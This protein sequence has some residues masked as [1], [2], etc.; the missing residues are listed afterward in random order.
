MKFIE[1]IFYTICGIIISICIMGTVFALNPSLT[2]MAAN[3]LYE[4]DGL[5]SVNDEKA[6]DSVDNLNFEKDNTLDLETEKNSYEEEIGEDDILASSEADSVGQITS[7]INEYENVKEIVQYIED[8]E[9]EEVTSGLGIGNI[10]GELEFDTEIYPYYG[11][12]GDDLKELY[13][14]I[15]TNTLEGNQSFAPIVTVYVDQVSDAFEAVYNDHPELFWLD[16]TYTCKYM[17]NE[18][19]VE[20]DLSFNRTINDLEAARIEFEE[21]VNSILSEINREWNSYDK[22][23]Y[24]HD[25]LVSRVEYNLNSDMNQSAYSALVN[26]RSVCA[27]YARSFQYLMQRL[28]IPC[29][30]ST[31]ISEGESHAWNIVKLEDGY[32]N[33]DLTWADTEPVTYDYFNKSDIEFSQSHERR[34]LS[35]NL[36]KCN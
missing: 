9:A 15:Y 7:E 32:Y 17:S 36:P 24:V 20:I 16:S 10:D 28:G 19:C 8:D 26:G 1:K 3:F 13:K 14:Q 29:Y 33:V 31:G 6:A 34:D 4:T 18:M 25:L 2:Q 23:R 5:Y 35:V 30:Y 11:M 21:S 27:G 22:E 12:L